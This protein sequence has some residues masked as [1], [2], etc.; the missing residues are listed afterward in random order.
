M[1]KRTLLLSAAFLGLSSLTSCATPKP[2]ADLCGAVHPIYLAPVE[3]AGITDAHLVEL[4]TQNRVI[5]AACHY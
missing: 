5:A 2:V 3:A 1:H 4:V